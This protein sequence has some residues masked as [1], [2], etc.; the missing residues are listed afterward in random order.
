MLAEDVNYCPRCGT[1]LKIEER[2]GEERPVCPSCEWIFFPDPKVAVAAV[3]QKQDKV[4]LVKRAYNPF[5]GK[6]MLPAGF[7]DAGEDPEKAAIREVHE[8]TNLEIEIKDLMMVLS[9]QEYDKG[10]H[11]IIVYRGEVRDGELAA[12]DDA[13]DAGYFS[14]KSL[15]PLAFHSSRKILS[16]L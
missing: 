4:L 5:R 6:W 16:T 3:I 14:R 15:P 11:I 12:G 8:E 10:A 9:G 7:V 1:E 13:A 2:I